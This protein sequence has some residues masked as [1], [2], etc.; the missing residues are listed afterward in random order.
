MRANRERKKSAKSVKKNER[1]IVC[2]I[3]F[4]ACAT[5]AADVA[6]AIAR[7]LGTKL[8]IV[9]SEDIRGLDPL[10]VETIVTEKR[11]GLERAAE[12][13]RELGTEVEEHLSSGSAFDAIVDLAE[14]SNA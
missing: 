2:G 12:G 1:P 7:K 11:R 8:V 9:H 3:D 10:L 5:E 14:Q 6:A 4:S 13:L